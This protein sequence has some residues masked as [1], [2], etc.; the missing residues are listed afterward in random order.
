MQPFGHSGAVVALVCHRA[1][2]VD[3]QGRSSRLSTSPSTPVENVQKA[4]RRR[5][6]TP[7][8]LL[9]L[10]KM[11]SC[12]DLFGPEYDP[13]GSER[14]PARPARPEP[15]T[16]EGE[17]MASSERAGIAPGEEALVNRA[18]DGSSRYG[19]DATGSSVGARGRAADR[20]VRHFRFCTM[21]RALR[22]GRRPNE[23]STSCAEGGLVKG[24]VPQAVVQRADGEPG[25]S[26]FVHSFHRRLCTLGAGGGRRPKRAEVEV[27][28]VLA[29]GAGWILADGCGRA[30]NPARRGNDAGRRRSIDGQ[31]ADLYT[32]PPSACIDQ[33]CTCGV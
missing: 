29:V 28:A 22:A 19:G 9:K 21:V 26:G 16:Q 31:G 4:E 6:H 17:N 30:P 8:F 1:K 5:P 15:R 14:G 10:G 25:A 11:V 7:P 3:L 2:I 12:G 33:L 18:L 13:P 20:E 24:L 27:V 23:V 32:S